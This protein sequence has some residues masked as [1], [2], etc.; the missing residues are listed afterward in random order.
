MFAMRLLKGE[1]KVGLFATL[2]SGAT[3]SVGG[4]SKRSNVVFPCSILVVVSPEEIKRKRK[5]K[6]KRK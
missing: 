2:N 3:N 4:M 1:Q 6:R 5:R